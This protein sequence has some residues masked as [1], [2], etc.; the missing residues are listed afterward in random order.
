[1]QSQRLQRAAVGAPQPRGPIGRCREDTRSVGFERCR[2]HR[3]FVPTKRRDRI[4][5][6]APETCSPVDRRSD[7]RRA[8]CRERNR[9]D[10]RSVEHSR[11]VARVLDA[12]T[13]RQILALDGHTKQVNIAIFSPNSKHILTASADQTACLWDAATGR[14]LFVLRGHGRS[15]EHRQYR[16]DARLERFAEIHAAVFSPDGRWIATASADKTA[17]IWD[18]HTGAEYFTLEGHTEAVYDVA[19]SADSQRIVTTSQDG[20]ARIWPIDPLPAAIAR[21]PRD[22]TP[23]ERARFRTDAPAGR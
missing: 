13:G 3:A 12:Q 16:R 19:F 7:H 6:H 20:T 5:R 8:I 14:K 11:H 21:K 17:R 2:H 23:A 15:S 9:G 22:L 4:T 10:A 1:M 18:A